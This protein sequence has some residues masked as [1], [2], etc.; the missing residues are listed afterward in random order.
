MPA[1]V[2]SMPKLFPLFGLKSEGYPGMGQPRRNQ[3]SLKATPYYHLVS[4]CVRREFLC[5]HDPLTGKDY[6]HRRR[7]IC[8]R[9]ERLVQIFAVDVCA[10]AVMSNHYHLVVRIDEQTARSWTPH[11]VLRRWLMLFKG[12]AWMHEVVQSGHRM[13]SHPSMSLVVA[14]YRSR[15]MSLSWFMRCINEPIA[16]RANREDEVNGHFWQGRYR[17]QALLDEGALMTAMTYV[18]LNPLRAGIV[19]RPE[20]AEYASVAQRF[21]HA[22][23]RPFPGT[24]PK[25]M[26]LPAG[27]AEES[28]GPGASPPLTLLEYLELIDWSARAV[29]AGKGAAM[30][31]GIPPVLSRLGLSS[32]MFGDFVA[33]GGGH[34]LA[35]LGDPDSLRSWA[36]SL[37]RHYFRGRRLAA[38]LFRRAGERLRFSSSKHVDR[39]QRPLPST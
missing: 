2:T 23:G 22:A 7:W 27:G 9:L 3:I 1:A 36:V 33:A 29:A 30:P 14:M 28:D 17:C 39:S 38:A 10:Y 11:E 21:A 32:E 34:G 37:G 4:R 26:A 31:D 25:L 13:A 35:V 15:L 20:D 16:R 24:G 12:P 6:S 19:E 5:G 8:Q 18:D